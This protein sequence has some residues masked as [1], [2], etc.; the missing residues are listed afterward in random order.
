MSSRALTVAALAV[1][2][3]A[4]GGVSAQPPRDV[5][6][7]AQPVQ[8]LPNGSFDA[9]APAWTQEPVTT[10]LICNASRIM[11][12]DGTQAACLG[13]TD[14]LVNT[15]SQQVPLPDGARSATLAGQICIDTEETQAADHDVL[16]FD[17]VDGATVI[18]AIG[19]MT[20][21]QGTK[22]C[23]FKALTLTAALTGDPA[24]ATLRIRST[25]DANMPT[26]FYLDA[27]T[28]NVSCTQ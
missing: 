13:G 3:P 6:C 5:A 21:Q 19:K 2:L 26:S 20:N 23:Q 28:L 4:C 14:G 16:Q 1:V 17:L 11:P 15:L 24:T 25:L 22:G 8:V 27:L 12:A 10:A 18:S 9:A 7:G